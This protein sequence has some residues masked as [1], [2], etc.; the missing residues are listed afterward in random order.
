MRYE[1][2]ELHDR[3]VTVKLTE[4]EHRR[5]R[6]AARLRAMRFSAWARAAL[7][8]RA[9][10]EQAEREKGKRTNGAN[11]HALPSPVLPR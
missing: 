1:T 8:D 7:I 5:V 10:A 3:R 9:A 2:I 11:G 6:S 4:T